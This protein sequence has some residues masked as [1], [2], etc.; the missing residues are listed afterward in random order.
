MKRIYLKSWVVY[1]LMGINFI[2]LLFMA[3]E[4]E[5]LKTFVISHLIAMIIFVLNSYVL[6]K[7]TNKK[8]FE[9]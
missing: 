2:S 3:G 5:D 9:L 8:M 6:V 4:C 1:F 7:Y